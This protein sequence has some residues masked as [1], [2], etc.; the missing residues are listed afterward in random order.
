MIKQSSAKSSLA[1]A[2]DDRVNAVSVTYWMNRLQ[3]IKRPRNF[4]VSLNPVHEP[5]APSVLAEMIY[6]HPVLEHRAVAAQSRLAELQGRNQL[7]FCG[8][9]A[10]YGF[11]EDA[12]RSAVGVASALGASLPWDKTAPDRV[13]PG[14]GAPL[15]AVTT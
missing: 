4:F 13:A 6:H 15:P 5:Q 2:R 11:H 12:L 3:N 14:H 8:S 10:G 1:S 7:W 9:Y